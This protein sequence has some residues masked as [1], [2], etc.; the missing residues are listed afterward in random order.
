MSGE[1]G[2]IARRLVEAWNAHDVEAA[3]ALHAES[4]EGSDVAQAGLQRGRQ[5]VRAALARYYAA[6]PDLRFEPHEIVADAGRAAI[7]WQATGT[8]QGVLMRIP[9]TGRWV[10]VWGTTML[11]VQDGLICTAR[12]IWDVAALLRALR[13]LPELS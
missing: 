1:S 3:A 9:P 6:F 12:H 8:H 10:Q 5:S 7:V 4:F 11:G 13:L 2:S